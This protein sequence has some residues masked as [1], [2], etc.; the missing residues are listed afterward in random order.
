MRISRP[1]IPGRKKKILSLTAVWG[2][3]LNLFWVSCCVSR[4]IGQCLCYSS[5]RSFA[6]ISKSRRRP[7]LGSKHGKKMWNWDADAK[8]ISTSKLKWN[9]IVP[10]WNYIVPTWNCIVPTWN[11]MVLPRKKKLGFL[12]FWGWKKLLAY[13]CDAECEIGF[14]KILF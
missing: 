7:Q 8:I 10:G 2:Q 9:H 4:P 14:L 3:T 5:Q 11:Y 13:F 1:D 12:N 6:M